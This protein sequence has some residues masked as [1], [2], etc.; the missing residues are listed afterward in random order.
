VVE[1]DVL[2]LEDEEVLVDDVEAVLEVPFVAAE[3]GAKFA[4]AFAARAW[5][6][7]SV[8]VELAVGLT[9]MTMVMPDWQCFPWE[10]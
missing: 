3:P 7:A 10:Q 4:V 6:L 8:R 5:K 2:L 9:L 1:L